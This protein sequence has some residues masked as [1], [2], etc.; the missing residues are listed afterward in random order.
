M[1][2]L[3]PDSFVASG[4][5]ELWREKKG[6]TLREREKGFQCSSRR[7]Q[8]GRSTGDIK[9]GEKGQANWAKAPITPCEDRMPSHQQEGA[10][11]MPID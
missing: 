11:S 7:D 1:H 9:L 4:N 2:P 3:V 10:S 8:G 5:R 6:L